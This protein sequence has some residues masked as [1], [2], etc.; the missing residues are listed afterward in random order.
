MT[1]CVIFLE[2]LQLFNNVLRSINESS[3]VFVWMCYLLVF[4]R[5]AQ[6]QFERER[7]EKLVI[8]AS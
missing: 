7:V 1:K 4:D 6:K 8:K 3:E 2:I 5:E